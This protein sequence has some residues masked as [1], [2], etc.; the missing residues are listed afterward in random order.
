MT[1]RSNSVTIRDVAR[2][3]G[4]SVATISRYVNQNTPVSAEL[5]GRIQ[6]VMLDLNYQPHQVARHLA[7]RRTRTVGMVL[8]NIYTEF[9]SPMLSGIESV[10]SENQ[11]NLLVTTY[12]TSARKSSLLPI[13]S[14]NTDGMLVFADCLDEEH[15]KQLHRNNVP[16]VLIHRTS[17]PNLKIPSVTVENRTA[18]RELIDH[19]IEAH[20]RRSILFLRGPR[21][22]EDSYSREQGYL[23]SLAAHG[24]VVN[25]K[26]FAEGSFISTVAYQNI[27]QLLSSDCAR[28]D[29]IFAGN[30]DAAIGALTALKEVGL[31]VPEDVAVVGF[32]DSRLSSFINPPLT[33]VR[34]PT[35]EV[36]RAAA[37]LLFNLIQ[38]QPAESTTLDSLGIILRRSCGCLY[39]TVATSSGFITTKEF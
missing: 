5:A 31:R 32:D 23:D 20:N 37:R 24:I 15:L 14:H 33:T 36:G 30:D 27:K 13:G 1:S 11:Y 2:Q 8:N 25:Q 19:L 28:F 17:P 9:F 34:T 21:N 12:K 7:T 18:T 29:A 6:R 16:L 4:V 26:L 38:G 35:E 39:D 22:Q 10:V 3:A